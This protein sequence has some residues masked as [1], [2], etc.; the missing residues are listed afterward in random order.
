[1]LYLK[2]QRIIF[3]SVNQSKKKFEMLLTLLEFYMQ[4]N[5]KSRVVCACLDRFIFHVHQSLMQ[6]DFMSS[7]VHWFKQQ[8]QNKL[9]LNSLIVLCSSWKMETI[10]LKRENLSD[11]P[12]INS[13]LSNKDVAHWN[14]L[15][16]GIKSYFI[17]DEQTTT[18][19]SDFKAMAKTPQTCN[20][21]RAALIFPLVS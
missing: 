13:R 15:F 2:Y 9:F 10:P 12:Q 21:I 19:S 3:L 20:T 18:S 17:P 6:N 16:P 1:M 7:I 8:R 5:L 11:P 4:S 14:L